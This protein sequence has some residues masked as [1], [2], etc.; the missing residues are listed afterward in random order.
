LLRDGVENT[1]YLRHGKWEQVATYLLEV[2]FGA[3]GTEAN[4]DGPFTCRQA[5]LAYPGW[6]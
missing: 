4:S 6:T 5:D 2:L 1:V 3:R